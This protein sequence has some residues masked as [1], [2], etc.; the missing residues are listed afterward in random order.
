MSTK[1]KSTKAWIVTVDMG[2]GHQRATHALRHLAYGEIINA[3]THRGL[4]KKDKEIWLNGRKI[5]ESIS[6]FKHVPLIGNLV[7]NIFDSFQKIVLFYPRRD[8]SRP[9]LQLRGTMR[10]IKNKKW[11]EK[12]IDFLKIKKELSIITSFFIPAY[13]AEHFEY[14]SDIYCIICD[15]D[16]SRAWAPLNPAMSKIKYFAPT[17]RVVE[18]L[19]LYG[20]NPSNIYLTGFPL[21]LE[22]LGSNELD[23]L[24]HDL[25]HRLINLDPEKVYIN[26][27]KK[28]IVN[29]LGSDNFC[30]KPSHPLTLMFAVGGAGAQRELGVAIV[31]SLKKRVLNN[32]ININLVAGAHNDVANYFKKE[33][34]KLGLHSKIGDGI[35]I[36]LSNNKQDYFLKFNKALR[37]T[38]ILWTKPS[39]LSFYCA[40]GI[41][42]IIAPP[43]GSQEYFN[44]E[45]LRKLGAGIRQYDPKYCGEWLFDWVNSG[46]LAEAAIQGFLEAPNNGTFEIEKIIGL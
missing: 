39:E 30:Q 36:I 11:G 8:L 13:M 32:E 45:W 28:T 14:P 38:D 5:Y 31:K 1:N 23:I 15:A 29:Q 37:T 4:S 16:I 18:R 2:Y 10:A 3:N 25:G 20:V 9:T 12:L 42:I 21:P 7:C 46:W 6:R 26:Q 33:L 44:Q 40:L 43:I 34:S 17:E 41:P 27:Y 35:D 24:K 19:K 22:N